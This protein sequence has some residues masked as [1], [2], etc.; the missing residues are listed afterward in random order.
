MPRIRSIKPGFWTDENLSR[1]APIV[2]MTF[3]GLIS[4]MADDEGRCKGDLRLVKAA[5][6]PLD[7]DITR[8]VVEDHLTQLDV[9]E[10]IQRYSVKGSD[11]IWIVNWKKHQRIDKP[12]KSELP[13][14]PARTERHVD[15]HSENV[16]RN[17]DDVSTLDKDRRGV[18]KGEGV[19]GNGLKPLRAIHKNGNG[20]AAVAAREMFAE[21]WQQY[22]KRAGANPR[23]EA[24][25][26]W[27]ARVREGVDPAV[28]LDGVKRYRAFLEATGKVGSEFV[29]QGKRFFGKARSFEEHWQVVDAE[30][31]LLTEQIRREEDDEAWLAGRR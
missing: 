21:A 23:R 19:E 29:Q 10:R 8:A 2:R 15:E 31:D 4:A 20:A 25:Q 1:F 3:L 5:I 30:P 7:D 22:P 27:N 17:V 28:M 9:G 26:A 16:P 24:E 13:R 11:Y 14:P 6:W 18:G 12:R